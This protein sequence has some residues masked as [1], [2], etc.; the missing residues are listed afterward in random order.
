MFSAAFDV[1]IKI[2]ESYRSH[3]PSFSRLMWVEIL[4]NKSKEFGAFKKFKNL[5]KSKSN[6]ISIKFFRTDRGGEFTSEELSKWCEEKGI[7]RQLTT[8]HMP[9][10]NGVVERKNNTV[11]SLMRSI[12]KDKSL[13][14]E[15][16]GEAINTCMY[17]LNRSSTKS[18]QGKTP[19][20]MWSGKEP[21]LSHLR[22]FG[23]VLHVK[24][25]E[26]LGKLEDRSN[27][28][29]FVGYQRGTKCY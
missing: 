16:W 12:L 29:V 25:P 23:L 2:S 5:A 24:N 9:Q 19:Y 26:A 28:M 27:D 6:G 4:K 8:L 20:E 1:L 15:V 10:Q 13:P 17:V 3:N 21:K 22:I 11:I 7:Y 14:L 18:L